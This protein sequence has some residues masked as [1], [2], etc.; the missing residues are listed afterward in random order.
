M[1]LVPSRPRGGSRQHSRT[2]SLGVEDADADGYLAMAPHEPDGYLPMA[3][4]DSLAGLVSASSGS[5]CSGTPST[6]PR[7][8]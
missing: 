4:L 5:V 1:P 6:D 7:F 2:S 8:R 3:P